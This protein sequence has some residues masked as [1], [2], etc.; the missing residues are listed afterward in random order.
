MKHLE[1]FDDFLFERKDAEKV[2]EVKTF[3]EELYLK[4]IEFLIDATNKYIQDE[5][6]NVFSLNLYKFNYN[7]VDL[8][9]TKGYAINNALASYSNKR[10]TLYNTPLS[11]VLLDCLDYVHRT[12]Y[13]ANLP[14]LRTKRYDAA[15]ER[16][17]ALGYIHELIEHSDWKSIYHLTFHEMIHYYDDLKYDILSYTKKRMAK[18]Y[19]KG[20]KDE[21]VVDNLADTYYNS[22]TEVNAYFLDALHRYERDDMPFNTFEEF[23]KLF[24]SKYYKVYNDL[25]AE[26]KKRIMKRLYDYF[27]SK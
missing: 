4:Y 27:T 15:K 13:D 5:I 26:N 19:A 17:H 23:S 2:A 24:F 18:V 7:G 3:V 16:E 1:K 14:N 21:E 22:T 11:E 6:Q 20:G 25:N 12:I 8:Q 9:I 10:I